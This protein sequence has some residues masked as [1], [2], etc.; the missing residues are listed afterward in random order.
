MNT[1]VETANRDRFANA[2]SSTRTAEIVPATQ[3]CE[4]HSG[5]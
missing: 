2:P 1:M 4:D 3:A 5:E